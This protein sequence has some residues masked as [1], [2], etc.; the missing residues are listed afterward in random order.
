MFCRTPR[1]SR[2]RTRSGSNGAPPRRRPRHA[3]HDQ[4]EFLVRELEQWRD[5]DPADAG[6]HHREDPGGRRR[7]RRVDPPQTREIAAVHHRSH[8]Q[9]EARVAEDQPERDRRRAR[10]ATKTATWSE[11]SETPLSPI[12]SRCHVS[13]GLGPMPRTVPLPEPVV[14]GSPKSRTVLPNASTSHKASAGSAMSRPIDPTIRRVHRRRREAPQQDPVEGE[15]E[16][17]GEDQHRDQRRR[18]DRH[19]EAG[20]QLEEDVGGDERDHAVREVED[21]RGLVGQDHPCCHDRVDAARHGTGEQQVQIV[22]ERLRETT[23]VTERGWSR[24]PRR[25]A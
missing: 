18:H 2:P 20:V 14:T 10:A 4:G 24:R 1:S 7:P 13:R 11:L 19:A 12:E 22:H 3:E 25:S 15:A 21:P 5:Q 8:L 9:S 17:R 6:E 23:T 16:Q